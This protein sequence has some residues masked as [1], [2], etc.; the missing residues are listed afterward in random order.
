MRRVLCAIPR[1]LR[2]SEKL[3]IRR[4]AESYNAPTEERS[5]TY[6]F[7]PDTGFLARPERLELP[8]YWFEA[9]RSI[10]LSY[11]RAPYDFISLGFCDHG[12]H[13]LAQAG[14]P[15]AALVAGAEPARRL[16]R[17]ADSCWSPRGDH[18]ARLQRE[19]AR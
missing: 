19:Y 7:G 17:E 18:I 9:S 15:H 6:V 3:P 8:T 4:F 1:S 10:H 12:I 5:V 14:D 13:Q 11:G 16:A 2:Q